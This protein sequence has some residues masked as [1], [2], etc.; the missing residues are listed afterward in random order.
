MRASKSTKAAPL[1]RILLAVFLGLCTG[2][3]PGFR[4][5]A[6]AGAPPEHPATAGPII[7]DTAVPTPPGQLIIQPYW[8]LGFVA[9]NFSP[10]WR[11]VSAGGNFRSFQ[12][13]LKITYGLFQ[14]LEIY[15]QM[16]FIHNWANQVQDS[17]APGRHSASFSG[18]SDLTLVL[19][20]Q[21]MEETTWRP[22][23]TTFL[24]VDFPTGHHF[25]TNPAR[26]GLDVQGGGAYAF[27]GGFNLSKWLGPVYLYSNLWYSISSR[28][29][30]ASPH[31]LASPLMGPVL[32]RDVI[33][34][35]MAAEWPLSGKWV[36][37]LEFYSSW[38]M[39]PL[40]H[41]SQQSPSI[42]MGVLPGIEYIFNPRWSCELGVALDLAGRNSLHGCTPIFSV[43]M[44]Y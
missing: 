39:N 26:L 30:G 40:F 37:L 35:N 11:R 14:N 21:L 6:A 22:T 28:E 23:V 3:V 2:D 33:T 20:Y 43:I 29:L 13:P 15:G 5:A 17:N 36:A 34:W 10:S 8:S 44:T 25:R 31:L 32:S 27:T 9:G 1:I 42:L 41:R 16:A 18:V 38:A 19:K 24:N 7:V 12:M 4:V